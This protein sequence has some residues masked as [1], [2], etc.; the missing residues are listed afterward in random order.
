M[1]WLAAVLFDQAGAWHLSHFVPRYVL[2]DWQRHYPLGPWR[3]Q[4]LMAFPR[5]FADLI[6]AGAAEQLSRA[7]AARDHSRRVGL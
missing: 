1:L 3:K 7:V 5:G 2:T 4:W 6:S